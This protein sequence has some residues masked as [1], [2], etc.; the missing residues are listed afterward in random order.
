MTATAWIVLGGTLAFYTSIMY[1]VLV[2]PL[3]HLRRYERRVNARIERMRQISTLLQHDSR[4]K[5]LTS[6]ERSA[7]VVEHLGLLRRG[8]ADLRR[9]LAD[10]PGK[11][12][13]G[14]Q[15]RAS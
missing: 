3:L 4:E 6:D 2:R 11:Q 13:P 10:H 12:E 5:C 8:L 1:I 14:K 15:E 9:G 7:L